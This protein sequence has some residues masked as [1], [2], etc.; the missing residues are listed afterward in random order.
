MLTCI[1]TI[2]LDAGKVVLAGAPW[3]PLPLDHWV[4]NCAN[5]QAQR[6]PDCE[7]IFLYSDRLILE[8]TAFRAE[9]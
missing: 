5:L 9:H 8:P 2:T 3:R 6:W 1:G 4:L 7:P